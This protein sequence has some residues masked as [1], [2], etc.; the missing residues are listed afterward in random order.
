[1][2]VQVD[3]P[4]ATG[5]YNK[6]TLHGSASSKLQAVA[7]DD[8]DTSILFSAT[9]G[10]LHRQDFTFP[11]ISGVA[12]PVN[13]ASLSTVARRYLNGAG[14]QAY[15]IRWAGSSRAPNLWSSLP[16]RVYRYVTVTYT[17]GD[18]G[19]LSLA[20]VNGE[21]GMQFNA[22]GGPTQKAE[23]WVTQVYRTV[24]FTYEAGSAGEFAHLIGSLVGSL[25][26]S[27]LL[28]SHMADISALMW[29]KRR[30]RLRPDEF[31]TAL[32]AWNARK[33]LVMA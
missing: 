28:L 33:W 10:Q 1:M 2:P 27:G 22:A 20:S 23:V 12:D 3:A 21:H 6:W 4:I 8:G 9:G 14:G 13:S 11:P 26:G 32:D 30:I 18:G 24:D 16:F 31:Q 25:L 5:T 19:T 17:A 29:A 7:T 15:H